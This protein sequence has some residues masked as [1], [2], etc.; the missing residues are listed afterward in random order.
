MEGPGA[1]NPIFIGGV[2]RSGTTLLRVILDT[3]PRIHC[4][5]ELRVVQSL[6]SLWSSVEQS[7]QPLLADAYDVD[8]EELRRIFGELLMSFLEPAWR[9]S[10]KP[11]VAEKTPFNVLVFPELRRLF[12]DSPLV[13]VIRD[14]RD[15]VAS[16]LERER[17]ASKAVD[18]AAVAAARA[19][20]WVRTMA[21]RRKILADEQL[22]RAYYEIRY[23]QLVQNPREVLEPLFEFLEE[24]F[25]P[26]VLDFHRVSRNVD[27]TEEWSAAA[28]QRPIFASSCGRWRQSLS[29]EEHAAVMRAAR[30][31]LEE[32]G[33]D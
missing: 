16:R 7:G 11:R 3:H 20:E 5:T 31:V 8:T 23:E 12:P 21:V 13:H 9:A 26:G 6:T 22:S 1:G 33:Y 28:V 24:P 30:P 4:G 2:P 18:T 14:V 17:T 27:G 15:V 25:E 19:E 32:L 29:D 10:G